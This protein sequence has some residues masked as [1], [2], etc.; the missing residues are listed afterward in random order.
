MTK[1]AATAKATKKPENT[2]ENIKSNF[3]NWR[4]VELEKLDTQLFLCDRIDSYVDARK[5]WKE[6]F[7]DK[8]SFQEV[9]IVLDLCTEMVIGM[10]KRVKEV[11][12]EEFVSE[13]E[14]SIH[15]DLLM[16]VTD[17]NNDYDCFMAM[18]RF[19]SVRPYAENYLR[20]RRLA[21]EELDAL[22]KDAD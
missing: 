22:P 14:E 1:R 20:A 15:D 7:G 8:P 17:C 11:T 4:K 16:S 19:S 12:W 5:L 13:A 10:I 9:N 6:Y 21:R 3:E 2:I 18:I